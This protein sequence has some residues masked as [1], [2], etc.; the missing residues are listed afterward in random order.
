ML[1]R[2]YPGKETKDI[3][4]NVTLPSG[5]ANVKNSCYVASILHCFFS[6]PPL[7]ELCNCAITDKSKNKGMYY[8]VHVVERQKTLILNYAGNGCCLRAIESLHGQYKYSRQPSA[9]EEVLKRG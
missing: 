2:K 7:N 5:F 4:S 8:T 1:K 6:I 9:W 3:G